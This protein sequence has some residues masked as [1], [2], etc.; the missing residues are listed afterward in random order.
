MSRIKSALIIAGVTVAA[1][2]AGGALGVMFAPASG[3]ET[4]RRLAWR[5]EQWRSVAR[6]S[7]RLLARAAAFAREELENRKRR[8]VNPTVSPSITFPG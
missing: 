7:E 1:G 3:T 5:T 8:T 2:A 4:R 6:A